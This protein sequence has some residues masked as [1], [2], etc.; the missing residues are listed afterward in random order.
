[1]FVVAIIAVPSPLRR[2]PAAFNRAVNPL[3]FLV[4]TY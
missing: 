2:N 3:V 4:Y 1:M